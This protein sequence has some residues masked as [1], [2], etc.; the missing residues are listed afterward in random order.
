MMALSKYNDSIVSFTSEFALINMLQTFFN[1]FVF[2]AAASCNDAYFSSI[3]ILSCCM[4]KKTKNNLTMI[5]EGLS[6][7]HK[8]N[9]SCKYQVI[10]SL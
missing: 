4:R 3:S 10:V 2:P 8:K 7:K 5:K 1:F 9:N 6:D